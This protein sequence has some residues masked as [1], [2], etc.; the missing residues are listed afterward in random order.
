MFDT[1]AASARQNSF[2]L[3]GGRVLLPEGK[4]AET[5]LS[6]ENGCIAGIG[7]DARHDRVLDVRN[8]LILPGIIDLH[9]D[10]F[11]RQLMPRPGVAFDP[12]L[13][14][15][16]TDRQLVTNGITTAYHGL[17]WSWEPGLRG[18]EAAHAFLRALSDV[19]P[20][21]LAD[22]RLHLRHETYNL[23]AERQIMDWL[24]ERRVDLLA[25]NDH[26]AHIAEKLDKPDRLAQFAGRSGLSSAEFLGLYNK[27][28]ERADEVEQSIMRLADA[29]RLVHVPMASHDDESKVDRAWFHALG[30]SISEFPVDESTAE[31]AIANQD[32]VIL[33][34]PNVL[35]GQSHCGRLM[36]A[37][38]AARGLCTA[39]ASDYYY[40]ALL[41]APFKLARDGLLSFADAWAL[42]SRNP[43]KAVGLHDRGRL[44]AGLRADILIV[45]DANPQLA[46]LQ[47]VVCA[48]QMTQLSRF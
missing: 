35:R 32:A 15:I 43:A 36:A 27:V 13:A 7:G 26:M 11:E 20:H 14:L 47:A 45:N 24:G 22:T 33:G 44:E 4:I 16:D 37:D 41:Q 40:P 38:M 46:L 23:D 19:R 9:G 2:D 39:L 25:F 30:C 10:A 1:K 8:A 42:V 48:G 31:F 12:G 3:V 17:T 21:L 6:I 34:A 28:K 29:A 18:T 5:C